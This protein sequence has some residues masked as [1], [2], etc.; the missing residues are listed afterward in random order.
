M[1]Y[2]G[3]ARTTKGQQT[4]G[5]S[6][7]DAQALAGARGPA[8]PD[9]RFSGRSET[10][11]AGAN[12]IQAA[13]NAVTPNG[14]VILSGSYTQS[15]DLVLRQGVRLTSSSGATITFT[16]DAKLTSPLPGA[17]PALNG[18]GTLASG[19]QT[20]AVSNTLSDDACFLVVDI[21]ALGTLYEVAG[22]HDLAA[23]KSDLIPLR[24]RTPTTLTFARAPFFNYATG[25]RLATRGFEP[26]VDVAIDGN[27]TLIKNGGTGA[28]ILVQL[29]ALRRA[30]LNGITAS[31]TT[32]TVEH[33][34]ACVLFGCVEVAFN[35]CTVT[36][37]SPQGPDNSLHPYAMK[38]AGC[39]NYD[40]FAH[41]GHSN[42]WHAMDNESGKIDDIWNLPTAISSAVV[43]GQFGDIRN[44]TMS[45]TNNNFPCIC[46]TSNH[47]RML[48]LAF[49]SGGGTSIDGYAHNIE[50]I[51][52]S[53]GGRNTQI[54]HTRGV[55]ATRIGH[56]DFNNNLGNWGT[57]GF[58]MTKCN[59]GYL[60]YLNPVQR[61]A[62]GRV[63]HDGSNTFTDVD[64]ATNGFPFS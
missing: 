4:A 39:A 1:F 26:T 45:S 14:T 56:C 21:V 22:V 6:L 23:K 28:N 58:G 13:I 50:T 55:G 19:A 9:P 62:L 20:Y 40:V 25:T 43:A 42:D 49:T 54:A 64:A 24:S 18:G 51:V 7:A 52:A 16:N 57:G 2:G 60:H 35:G 48:D 36:T 34:P 38:F 3:V 61:S 29:N 17:M 63:P 53:P 11:T 8:L 12:S 15:V 5:L 30:R 59:Y 37:T 10:P 47:I 33:L 41:T 31:Q 46:H 27:I 44:S 32:T